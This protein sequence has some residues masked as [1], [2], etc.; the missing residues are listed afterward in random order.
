MKT[1]SISAAAVCAW[2]AASTVAADNNVVPAVA[3][4]QSC[5]SAHSTDCGVPTEDMKQARELF[6]HGVRLKTSGRDAE[7][8]DRFERASHLVPRNIEF[9]TAREITRQAMVLNHLRRGNQL[10]ESDKKVE[11]MAEFSAALEL[12]PRNEFAMQRLRDSMGADGAALSPALRRVAESTEIV[13]AP[14]A[15]TH[16]F[17]YRGGTRELLQ[18]AARAFGI[19]LTVD[20]SVAARPVRFDLE[21]ADYYNAMAAVQKTTKTFLVPLGPKEVMAVS[22]TP[23][24]RTQLER[25]SLQTFYLSE[26]AATQDLNELQN[27]LRSVFE[28]RFVSPSVANAAITVR[29]PRQ[30]LEAA[31]R[32]L[33]STQNGP[34]QVLL[35]VKVYQISRS[36]LRALGIDLPLQFQM[37]NLSSAV[38]AAALGSGGQSIQDLI[39]QLIAS[40]GINQANSQALQALLAQAGNQQNSLF[41]NPLATFGGGITRF[42]I[43]VTPATAKLQ[44]NQSN[45]STLEHLTLRAAQGNAATFRVGS[46]YPILNATFAPVF[47]S[48]ALSQVIQNNSF[49][50]PFP[51]FSYEDLGISLKAT[52]FVHGDRDVSLK[53]ELEFKSLTGDQFNG[54]PVIANRQYTGSITVSNGEPA[55]MVGVLSQSDQRTL[56][57]LPGLGYIPLLGRIGS[58][59]QKERTEDELLVTITPHIVRAQPEALSGQ[60]VRR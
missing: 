57:G 22:D 17:H 60:I 11:A 20:E 12:D 29:A 53:L 40:G 26:T 4:G 37:F 52:P 58:T 23:E 19:T 1:R 14:D 54:V 47:N 45:V 24:N 35:D 36:T 43:A 7:A 59:D 28:I 8:L 39:N 30:T 25:M 6:Q 34:P 15:G 55:V 48:A 44:F 16:D 49:Q 41:A 46:R 18:S 50:A 27:V 13:L 3:A 9:A 31:A 51:S 38:L 32:F 33:S 5:V 2:L 21:Q 10:L 42:G 56:R